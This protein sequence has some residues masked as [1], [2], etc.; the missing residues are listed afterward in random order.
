MQFNG[1]AQYQCSPEAFV[2]ISTTPGF[3]TERIGPLLKDPIIENPQQR[4]VSAWG[5]VN[6]EVVPAKVR[7]LV[8]NKARVE[9]DEVW[10]QEAPGEFRAKC[11]LAVK[12]LPVSAEFTQTVTAVSGDVNQC[13]WHVDGDYHVLIPLIGR[14]VENTVSERLSQAFERDRRIVNNWLIAH[15]GEY[16]IAQ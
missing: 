8:A 4:T 10:V 5:C 2:E 1:D 3:V 13:H 9:Y 12:G 14:S 15:A 16:P 6:P 7:S 11:T